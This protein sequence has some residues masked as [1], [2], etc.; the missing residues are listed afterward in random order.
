MHV[1]RAGVALL[2]ATMI[3]GE[4]GVASQ[5]PASVP[6]TRRSQ[7]IRVPEIKVSSPNRKV[8]F[9][10]LASAERL[11]YTLALEGATVLAPSPIAF[12]LDGYE[13]STGLVFQN[14]ERYEGRET[15]PWRGARSTAVSAFNGARLLLTN[16]LTSTD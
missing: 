3:L 14:E 1:I 8:T 16:D 7:R 11:T 6:A 13:L 4:S 15:Y 9:T 2:F 10:L 12:N 5:T